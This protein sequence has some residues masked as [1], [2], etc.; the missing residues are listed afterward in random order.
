MARKVI[1]KK[2]R[3]EK[4]K[5]RK[6]LDGKGMKILLIE[7]E[8]SVRLG[9]SCTLESAGY[10][11]SAEENGIDGMKR[12]EKEDF[13]IVI[14]DLRL[15]G[16]DGIDV[17]KSLRGISPDIGVI[18]ITAFAE[19]KTALE[20]M[21]AGA[22]DYIAK[23]FDPGELLS[24]IDGFQ[25]QKGH[26]SRI[27]NSNKSEGGK[28]KEAAGNLGISRETSGKSSESLAP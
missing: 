18:I 19:P 27:C 24:V 13:D 12:F 16:A 1:D 15:P 11:V 14:T 17:L 10:T 6:P 4:I 9:I 7:D 26:L 5:K 2:L 23:P 21:R 25:K 3:T 22:Y 8:L 28:K 20:A